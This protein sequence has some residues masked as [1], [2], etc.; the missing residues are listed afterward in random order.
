MVGATTTETTTVSYLQERKLDLEGLV[1]DATWKEILLNLVETNELDPW[2]IDI[3][4]LVDGYI[5]VV[6]QM[7]VP[8]LRIPANIVLA[9]SILLRLKSE[10]LKIIEIEETIEGEQ[11]AN[12]IEYQRVLPE[13]EALV[14]RLRMQPKRKVSLMELMDALENAMDIKEERE[15]A[16]RI[17]STPIEFMINNEDIDE[18][19]D[20][21]YAMVNENVDKE[22]LTTF[23]AL[24]NKF[25]NRESIL[26][27]LFIPLLFLM[28]D[29]KLYMLQDKF[30]DEIFIKV[31]KMSGAAHG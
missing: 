6:R 3:V 25:T 14:P 13:I 20:R 7:T 11:D 9:A 4:K 29:S 19:L 31:P 23:A 18:K 10:T 21:V 28:H 26:L 27:D 17:A 22:K 12:A 1:R 16:F 30:F 24:A 15:T 2:D 8:D 5:A